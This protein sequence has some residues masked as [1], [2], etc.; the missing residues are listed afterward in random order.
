MRRLPVPV[1][2]HTGE[3]HASALASALTESPQQEWLGGVGEAAAFKRYQQSKLANVVFT[4]ALKVCLPFS[5][6]VL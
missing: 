2:E 3:G 4:L 6:P 1:S 5:S